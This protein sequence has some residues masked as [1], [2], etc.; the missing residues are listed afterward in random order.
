MHILGINFGHDSSA[1]LISNGKIACCIEEEKLSRVKQDFGWPAEAIA[2]IFR[3]TGLGAADI[4]V[5]AFGSQNFLELSDHEI[6]FRFRKTAWRR[7]RE[8]VSRIGAYYGLWGRQFGPKNK[9]VFEAEIRAAG[10]SKAKVC[11]FEHHL[12]HA[13]SAWYAAP[14]RPD[15]AITCDGHGDGSAFNFYGFD[16]ELGLIP[17]ETNAYHASIGQFYSAVTRLLGFRPNR[18]EGKITGLAAYGKPT[19]L[20]DALQALFRYDGEKNL[21]RYPFAP[22]P[23][24]RTKSWKTNV[25]LSS[26]EAFIGLDYARRGR[27]LE[28]KISELSAG[29]SREDIAHACQKVTENLICRHTAALIDSHFP[30]KKVKLALAGGVFANVR[31]NQKLLELEAVANL[32]VQPAMGDAGLSLGAAVLASLAEKHQ[33]IATEKFRFQHAF[34]GPSFS[35]GLPAFIASIQQKARV[36]KMENPA[37]EIAQM[38]LDNRIV[39]LWQGSME[40]GPRALG[41]RS[42]ILNTFDRQVNDTLNQRLGRTE[43]MPFAPAVI[44]HAASRYFPGYDPDCP[45]AD[46]MTITYDVATEYQALLQ[47]VVHV[48]GTARPQ[49]VRRELDPC[50]YGILEAYYKLSGC[51]AVVN[52]SFN[53]HE[54]PIVSTPESAYKALKEGRVDVLVL[55]GYCVVALPMN[56]LFVSPTNAIGGAEISLIQ[57]TKYLHENG[58]KVFIALPP[59][60]E[61]AFEQKLQP[62][63][64]AFL[65]VPMMAWN[66]TTDIGCWE[67]LKAWAYRIYKSKGGWLYAPFRIAR[68]IRKHKIDLVHTNTIMALDGALAAKM[69]GVPHVQHLR[70]ITGMRSDAIFEMP[71]QGY[72]RLFGKYWGALQTGLVANSFY[73]KKVYE[74]YFPPERI[75]VL[76]NTVEVEAGLA[77]IGEKCPVLYIG[78][79]AN[80]SSKIKNHARFIQIAGLL[81]KKMPDARFAIFG[82][83]P[84]E[85]DPY[86]ASLRREQAR[87]GLH[88]GFEF[89]GLHQ[90]PAEMFHQIKVLVHPYPFESFGRIFIEA[91]AFGIPVVAARGGG[92]EELIRH[93]QNGFL[94][95]ENDLES[96]AHHIAKVLEDQALYARIAENGRAFARQFSSDKTGAALLELYGQILNKE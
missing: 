14:F 16:A 63:V 52:T 24:K 80:V 54:E 10:F 22:P 12:S 38:L 90:N 9:D 95:G 19:P 60:K 33:T 48:D 59:S 28:E 31:V 67:A 36:R 45:A 51:G 41:R 34:L 62:F 89:K 70:E 43:F 40:W 53:A 15:L 87:Q 55:E 88:N 81:R 46:Y 58:H 50:F 4:D 72:P 78:M 44:D 17:F 20:A 2:A 7:W 35:K 42:I 77:P 69:T 8:L 94:F 32:F 11:F 93:G 5:L 75:K 68:F 79:V 65:F 29:F 91:M 74:A 96:A 26:S 73:C 27:A 21:L 56:I 37:A 13:A 82:K 1:T 92:A 6:R 25:N 84:P 66:R 3:Q 30:H 39:G 61:P 47:A 57:M 71:G 85:T 49:I 64:Q 83:C 18:H 86:L 23:E 76:Y